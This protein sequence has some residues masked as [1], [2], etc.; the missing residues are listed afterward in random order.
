MALH[1][2]QQALH[3]GSITSQGRKAAVFLGDSNMRG[4]SL[5]AMEMAG[6]FFMHWVHM[7]RS[8]NT[9]LPSRT[10]V[11]HAFETIEMSLLARLGPFFDAK[12]RL[13]IFVDQTK[14]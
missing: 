1:D 7:D 2:Y 13:R 9:K 10:H 12:E 3:K 8:G 4:G 5:F 11:L 6:S 14:R